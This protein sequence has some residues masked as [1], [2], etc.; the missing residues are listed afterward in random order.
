MS[1]GAFSTVAHKCIEIRKDVHSAKKSICDL[2]SCEQ[3][4]KHCFH[5]VASNTVHKQNETGTLMNPCQ[6]YKQHFRNPTDTCP[7]EMRDLTAHYNIDFAAS[8]EHELG[9][10]GRRYTG[11]RLNR[12]SCLF[13]DTL[14]P[15]NPDPVDLN[16]QKKVNLYKTD[17]EYSDGHS[18]KRKP[19]V[20]HENERVRQTMQKS[21][22]VEKI[23]QLNSFKKVAHKGMSN[24]I[25][26]CYETDSTSPLNYDTNVDYS[27]LTTNNR[28]KC[29]VS[30]RLGFPKFEMHKEVA[31]VSSQNMQVEHVWKQIIISR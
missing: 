21:N 18:L 28:N 12:N 9:F 14:T 17:N 2:K 24:E 11:S 13:L 27:S 15:H 29:T 31:P 23:F 16:V 19:Q 4:K 3:N 10:I 20:F 26:V 5:K 25:P 8:H 7:K 30:G 1:S 6:T 22:T